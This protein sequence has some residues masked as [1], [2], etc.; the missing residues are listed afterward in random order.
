MEELAQPMCRCLQG[1]VA[2]ME[3]ILTSEIRPGWKMLVRQ[4]A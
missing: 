3:T 1:P 2:G 4:P